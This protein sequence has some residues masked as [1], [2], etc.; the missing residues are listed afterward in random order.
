[1]R[2]EEIQIA[3]ALLHNP[4]WSLRSSIVLPGTHAK[5]A[6][7]E[8]GRIVRFSTYLTG[9]LFAVLSRHS[10]LGRLLPEAP[11]GGAESDAAAFE[12]GLASAL[13]SGPGDLSHQLFATRTLGLTG[14]LPPAS[15]AD[16]LSGLLI[17]HEL[18]SGLAGVAETA[19]VPLVM[20]GEPKLCQRYASALKYMGRPPG[21][22][23]DNSAPAGLW[24]F[25][26][27]AGLL[28]SH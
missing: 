3:G 27:A 5:W 14:R 24:N 7:I 17:G 16:Y 28:A 21:A 18:V 26:G 11:Q 4:Q 2:G 9:E 6:Q 10:I 22:V 13:A 15:L 25:A 8:N 19:T 1:M 23:L 12:M 20:I